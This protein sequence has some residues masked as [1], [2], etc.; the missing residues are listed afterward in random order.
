LFGTLTAGQSVNLQ[1]TF[2]NAGPIEVTAPVI[3]IFAPAPT[4]AVPPA[5]PGATR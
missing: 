5:S 4:A 2:A 1:L 3:A